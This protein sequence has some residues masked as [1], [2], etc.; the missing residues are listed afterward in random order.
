MKVLELLSFRSRVLNL[1]SLIYPLENFNGRIYLKIF[2]QMPIVVHKSV[3]YGLLKQSV[4]SANTE[5]STYV[6]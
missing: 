5:T 2:V 3:N 6:I 4:Q 1:Y